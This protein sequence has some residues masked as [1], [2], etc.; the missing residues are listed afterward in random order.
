MFNF[1][2]KNKEQKA[3]GEQAQTGAISGL[4]R[5]LKRTR[6]ALASGISGIFSGKDKIDHQTLEE[7][8]AKLL[9]SDVGVTVTKQIIDQLKLDLKHEKIVTPETVL[10]TI[11]AQL[12]NI[13]EP[14]NQP[15]LIPENIRPFVI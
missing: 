1:F 4:F 10:T 13:L 15:L 7:L 14:C 12:E 8:E 6:D 5:G 3:A 2:K 11:K 9:T